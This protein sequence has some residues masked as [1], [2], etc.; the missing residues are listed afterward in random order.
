MQPSLS[1]GLTAL[2]RPASG[3][4]GVS[5]TLPCLRRC[6]SD[7]FGI[8]PHNVKNM[9]ATTILTV[10][11]GATVVMIGDGQVSL[12]NHVVKPNARKVRRKDD[13]LIGM[14]G[15]T[16]DALT[17]VGRLENKLEEH[18]GQLMRACVDLAKDWRTQK[19]LR[20]LE[21][22]I[23]VADH[24]ISLM[25]SGQGDVLQPAD[26]ILAIGSGGNYALSA[27]RALIDIEGMDAEAIARKSMQI[28][29]DLCVYTNSN[30]VVE[31][32]DYEPSDFSIEKE[33]EAEQ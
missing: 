6:H 2:L 20:N 10:R 32:L 13:V 30:F 7:T 22:I 25:V 33:K 5:A 23:V 4:A 9:R 8:T 27:A 28:A 15:A 1:R 31:R 19:V 16:A 26:N 14:A 3:R 12:G 21:A 29:A 11:K 18:P 17:L 24:K